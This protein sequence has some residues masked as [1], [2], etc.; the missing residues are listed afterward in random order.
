MPDVAKPE[1]WGRIS[2]GDH[3]CFKQLVELLPDPAD[4]SLRLLRH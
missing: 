4:T 3:D 2:Q 1:K